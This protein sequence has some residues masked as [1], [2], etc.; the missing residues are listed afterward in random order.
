MT[1]PFPDGFGFSDTFWLDYDARMMRAL[2]I[3]LAL[4]LAQAIL[5]FIASCLTCFPFG[6]RIKQP[7]RDVKIPTVASTGEKV[8]PPSG[9]LN[10]LMQTHQIPRAAL[11]KK[12]VSAFQQ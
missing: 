8:A 11:A 1:Q 12:T 5:F 9:V 7:H 6:S 2:M 3:G 4:I 10:T